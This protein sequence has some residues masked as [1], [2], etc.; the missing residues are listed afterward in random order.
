MSENTWRERILGRNAFLACLMGSL[1]PFVGAAGEAC[2]QLIGRWGY[3]VS[4]AIAYDRAFVYIGN[5]TVLQIYDVTQPFVPQWTGEIMLGGVIQGITMGEDSGGGAVRRSGGPEPARP[6]KDPG[7][8]YAYIA[9]GKAGLTIVDIGDVC[10]PRIAGALDLPGIS[11]DVVVRDGL[12]Y[13]TA[14]EYGSPYA[15]EHSGLY[16]IGVA[17]PTA[18]RLISFFR[19]PGAKGLALHGD[20]VL[21]AASGVLILEISDP[22]APKVVSSY[23]GLPLPHAIRLCAGDGGGKTLGIVGGPFGLEIM[24]LTDVL[25]PVLVGLFDWFPVYDITLRGD[26]AYLASLFDGFVT[27]NIADPARPQ[28][29]GWLDTEERTTG[30]A[31]GPGCAVYLSDYTSLRAVDVSDP[32]WPVEITL[33]ETGH[34]MSQLLQEYPLVYA[35]ATEGGVKIF[36]YSEISAPREIGRFDTLGSA[37]GMAKRGNLLYVA[38]SWGVSILEVEDPAVPKE[39]GYVWLSCMAVDVEEHGGYLFVACMNKGLRI[40]DA[41]DPAA[42]E[43]VGEFSLSGYSRS[44]ALHG[45]YLLVAADSGGLVALNIDN[46]LLP[47]EVWRSDWFYGV[48]DVAVSEGKA[49]AADSRGFMIIVGLDFPDHVGIIGYTAVGG[50]PQSVAAGGGRAFVG[51]W[52]FSVGEGIYVYDVS[53]A[54]APRQIGFVETPAF[55]SDVELSSDIL[56]ASDSIGGFNAFTLAGCDGRHERPVGAP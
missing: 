38:D 50:S 14:Y 21:V 56:F 5:G 37:L 44:L 3:G 54:S 47:R 4:Y 28:W 36:D 17:D 29:L 25:R 8:R 18:P 32:G 26:V 46:P 20:Y 10:A 2:P 13:L 55:V 19:I 27:V 15:G 51:S 35:A 48:S 42:A 1:A 24:D 53:D 34:Y 12:A 45:Q 31:L 52:V 22:S 7:G 23:D 49:Y 30:V 9:T 43:I 33:I 39:L 41:T 40:I 16:I 6:Y 11:G